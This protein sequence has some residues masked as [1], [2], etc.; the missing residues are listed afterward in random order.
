VVFADT[1][2]LYAFLVVGDT[3]HQEA[4]H[5]ERVLREHREQL[6]TIDSVVTELWL[7]L[8]RD[9]TIDNCDRL[10]RGVLDRGL[11]RERL[12]SQDYVRAWEIGRE[13]SDQTF[14]L[15]DRQA[16]AAME[17]SRRFRAWSYDRDFAIFRLGPARARA[18]DL[19]R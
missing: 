9:V 3:H 1:G 14:S 6:W 2:A 19:V 17:R 13:W 15:T 18:I 11:Q 10:V 16:F 12:E 4:V 8:R 7:L 5:A